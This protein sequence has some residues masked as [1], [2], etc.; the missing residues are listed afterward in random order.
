MKE[1]AGSK[2]AAPHT[3]LVSEINLYS[4]M[5]KDETQT[6][7]T[8]QKLVFRQPEKPPDSEADSEPG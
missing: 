4:Y 5:P 1:T 3:P 8:S 7:P 6:V 2:T